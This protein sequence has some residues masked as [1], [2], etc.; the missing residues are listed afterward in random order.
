[1]LTTIYTVSRHFQHSIHYKQIRV[2]KIKII[3]KEQTVASFDTTV[4]FYIN[5]ALGL[6]RGNIRYLEKLL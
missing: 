6:E 1:M 2:E 3:L 5:V 4:D